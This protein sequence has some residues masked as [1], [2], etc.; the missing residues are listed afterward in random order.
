M[1]KR[2]PIKENN[3]AHET[4]FKRASHCIKNPGNLIIEKNKNNLTIPKMTL[5]YVCLNYLEMKE[6]QP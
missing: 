1:R 5:K 3:K 2:Y 4:S 6:Q